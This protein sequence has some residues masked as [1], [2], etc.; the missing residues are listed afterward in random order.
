MNALKTQSY[1]FSG[2]R[3]Q[4]QDKAAKS[5]AKTNNIEPD[6]R[7]IELMTRKFKGVELE[8]KTGGWK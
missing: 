4:L 8:P 3:R 1:I 7:L 6:K 2:Y 5:P